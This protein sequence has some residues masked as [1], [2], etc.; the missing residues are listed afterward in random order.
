PNEIKL[1]T[2]YGIDGFVYMLH[3]VR[4]KL[5]DKDQ[6]IQAPILNPTAKEVTCDN[7]QVYINRTDPDRCYMTVDTPRTRGALGAIGGRSLAVGPLNIEMRKNEIDYMAVFVTA[8]D[9]KD[10]RESNEML[11]VAVGN[12]KM[13]LNEKHSS[14]NEGLSG[15]VRIN[16]ANGSPKAYALGPYGERVKQV[17]PAET[18]EG[19]EIN[20][21]PKYETLWYEISFDEKKNK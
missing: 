11:L 8:M 12:Q 1:Q 18:P 15:V 7:G 13:V 17:D 9:G 3:K 16:R 6:L 21:S 2:L 14:V 19:I 5:G 4:V 10:L 20:P